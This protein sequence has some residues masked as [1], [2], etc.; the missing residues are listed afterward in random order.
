MKYIL[1]ILIILISG[2]A[3]VDKALTPVDQT[4]NSIQNGYTSS[5]N[6]VS[7]S[8]NSV[9]NSMGNVQ[10]SYYENSFIQFFSDEE[11][12]IENREKYF[13]KWDAS[14]HYNIKQILVK[15]KNRSMNEAQKMQELKNHFFAL[16]EQKFKYITE[17]E[18]FKTEESIHEAKIWLAKV[19][20]PA[21]PLLF[22]TM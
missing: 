20:L 8:Y 1:S 13:V 19:L 11:T 9:G 16:A 17:S 18:Y 2:C 5:S 3:T 7:E 21:P 22:I 10:S 4:S 14:N 15:K 6:Y 12:T